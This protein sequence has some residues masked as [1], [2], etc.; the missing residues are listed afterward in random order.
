VLDWRSVRGLRPHSPRV[1]V[2]DSDCHSSGI[3]TRAA[4]RFDESRSSSR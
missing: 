1:P 4:R 2:R 3:R